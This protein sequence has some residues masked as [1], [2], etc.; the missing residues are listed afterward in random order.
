[1]FTDISMRRRPKESGAEAEPSMRSA[2]QVAPV[3][4]GILSNRTIQDVNNRLCNITG[5]SRDEL[6]GEDISVLHPP[7]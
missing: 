4:M 5:Y 1:M 3:G 7:R 2:F 6:I